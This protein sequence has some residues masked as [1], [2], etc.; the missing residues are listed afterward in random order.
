MGGRMSAVCALFVLV[1]PGQDLAVSVGGAA[2]PRG[3]VVMETGAAR[4]CASAEVAGT[5]VGWNAALGPATGAAAPGAVGCVPASVLEPLG[6]RRLRAGAPLPGEPP[7]AGDAGTVW[8]ATGPVGC[9]GVLPTDRGP[10]QVKELHPVEVWSAPELAGVE[11]VR[12]AAAAAAGA[13]VPAGAV[14]GAPGG[15]VGLP[16]AAEW[17][18]DAIAAER[19]QEGLDTPAR[20]ERVTVGAGPGGL[21]T[22]FWGADPAFSDL[23]GPPDA[24]AAWLRLFAD[25]RAVCVA[26]LHPTAPDRCTPQVGDLG[27]FVPARPDPLGHKD[28]VDG[29]CLDLRLFRTD[30]SRYEA[31][32]NRADDRPGRGR[33]YDG[34]T[35]RAFVA[36]AAGRPEVHPVLFNDPQAAGAARVPGHDDHIHLCVRPAP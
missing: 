16:L 6:E 5:L 11:A 4:A 14:R 7:R 36:F 18:A 17:G 10:V 9:N 30:G 25:W 12:A 2:W 29:R 15:R 27:W 24:I 1:P 33:A 35:T 3:A 19:A 20:A 31:F 13:P 34:A 22:H 32:W 28:H 8:A 21:Y 26:R 23:W